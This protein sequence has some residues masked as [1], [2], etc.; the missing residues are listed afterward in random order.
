MTNQRRQYFIEKS[1][2]KIIRLNNSIESIES[3]IEVLIKINND[4]SHD[5]A[6]SVLEH[7]IK[8]KRGLIDGRKREIEY[9]KKEIARIEP[10]ESLQLKGSPL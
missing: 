1:E 8:K 3:T 5:S 9:H 4:K 7:S 10:R 6:I 2:E